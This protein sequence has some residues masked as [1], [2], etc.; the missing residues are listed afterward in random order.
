MTL[1]LSVLDQS[2]ARAPDQAATALQETLQMAKWCEELGVNTKK[3]PSRG[4]IS[5]QI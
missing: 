4:S 5:N 2:L 3:S 1:K